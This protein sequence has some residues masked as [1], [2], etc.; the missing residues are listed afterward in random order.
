MIIWASNNKKNFSN[1]IKRRTIFIYFVGYFEGNLY[2]YYGRMAMK[3]INSIRHSNS[4]KVVSMKRLNLQ[5]TKEEG[6]Y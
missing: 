3:S 4:L 2:I 5:R 1:F 6:G